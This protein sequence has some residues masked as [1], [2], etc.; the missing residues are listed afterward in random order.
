MALKF[1]TSV[2]KGL[3]LNEGQ[4]VFLGEAFLPTLS[5]ISVN[6]GGSFSMLFCLCLITNLENKSIRKKH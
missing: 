3:K 6:K 2:A 1:Y 4:K 5:W